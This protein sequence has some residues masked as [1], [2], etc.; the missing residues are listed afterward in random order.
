MTIGN[1]SLK[2]VAAPKHIYMQKAIRIE[3]K[4]K[5]SKDVKPFFQEKK[6][7]SL[8]SNMSGGCSELEQDGDITQ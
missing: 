5:N 6:I 8:F 4:E 2:S 7:M 1:A 3:Q